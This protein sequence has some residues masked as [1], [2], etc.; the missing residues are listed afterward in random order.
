MNDKNI[1]VKS[2]LAGILIAIG[3]FSAAVFL[4]NSWIKLVVI[5]LIIVSGIVWLVSHGALRRAVKYMI[6]AVMVFAISFSAFEWYILWNAGYPPV[7]MPSQPGATVS[8]SNI[9][10]A[11]LT[12]V[13]QS[14]SNSPAF[15]LISLEYPGKITFESMKL[16]TTFRGGRIEVLFYQDS[17]N[18]GFRFVSSAGQSYHASVLSWRG[19]PFSRTFPQEQSPEETLKQIDN[20]GLSW[21]YN[22]AIEAYQIKTGAS[23]EVNALQV[24]IQWE[25]YGDYQGMTLLLVGSYE[26]NFAGQGVFFANFQPNGTLLYLNV[27][28]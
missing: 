22:R 13:V 28:S 18:L 10:N 8:Y 12:E 3:L 7:F 16:D 4:G 1:I 20:L 5:S 9:L 25:N 27:A 2:V 26:H 19:Q 23:P 6:L 11:S 24:S 21:F 15:G 17:S 14:A